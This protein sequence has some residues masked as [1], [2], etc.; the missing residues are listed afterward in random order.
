MEEKK[1]KACS[2]VLFKNSKLNSPPKGCIFKILQIS[3][4]KGI[5]QTKLSYGNNLTIPITTHFD[6]TTYL[7]LLPQDSYGMVWYGMVWDL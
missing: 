1:G 4:F 6:Y 7:T 3:D 5:V 2:E